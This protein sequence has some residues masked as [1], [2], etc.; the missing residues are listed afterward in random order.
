MTE[1]ITDEPFDLDLSSRSDHPLSYHFECLLASYILAK[2]QI[3]TVN[4][5][6]DIGENEVK[7]NATIF[8][9][10]CDLDLMLTF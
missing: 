5:V 7:F 3:S 10:S 9:E 8:T 1:V 2:F 6:R 4:S